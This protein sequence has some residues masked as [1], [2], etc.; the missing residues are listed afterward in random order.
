MGGRKGG[1]S[2]SS[3]QSARKQLCVQ[4]SRQVTALTEAH[5]LVVVLEDLGKSDSGPSNLELDRLG[6]ADR[7]GLA[8]CAL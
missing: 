6:V 5:A 7:C 2:P 4:V 3:F 8:V 1:S